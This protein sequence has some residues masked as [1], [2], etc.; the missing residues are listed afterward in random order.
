MARSDGVPADMK[1][2]PAFDELSALID[3]ALAPTR[4]LAV[5]W[6]LDIC[7]TCARVAETVVALKRAV[8]RAHNR[9]L[10]LP[11]LRRSVRA[12]QPKL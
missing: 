5:R 6:H 1:N 8:G 2:C 12:R 7:P 9:E 11:A 3:G 4:E 10:P